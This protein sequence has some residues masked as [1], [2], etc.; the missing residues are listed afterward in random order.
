MQSAARVAALAFFPLLLCLHA[1]RVRAETEP[2]PSPD[3][4]GEWYGWQTLAVDGSSLL[5]GIVAGAAIDDVAPSSIGVTAATWYGASAVFV[6]AVHEAHG[7]WP[8]AVGSLG[9]RAFLPPVTGLFGL[10]AGCSAHGDFEGSCARPGWAGG[11]MVGLAGAA[12]FD[13]IVAR[14]PRDRGASASPGTAARS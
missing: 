12:A 2:L 3:P 8:I 10:L 14:E 6:P 4:R 5:L 11:T 9:I 7:N 13:A 1:S